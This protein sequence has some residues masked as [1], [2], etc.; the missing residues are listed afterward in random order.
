VGHI[1]D[2]IIRHSD[3]IK[4]SQLKSWDLGEIKQKSGK[5]KQKTVFVLIVDPKNSKPVKS[6]Q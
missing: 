3:P 1:D 6:K 5:F 2:L 4:P